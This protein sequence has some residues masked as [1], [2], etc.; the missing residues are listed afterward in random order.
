MKKLG[1][2]LSLLVCMPLQIMSMN[3]IPTCCV[4][5]TEILR[6]NARWATV[7]EEEC[8][9]E[10]DENEKIYKRMNSITPYAR[11]DHQQGYDANILNPKFFC[12]IDSNKM[13]LRMKVNGAFSLATSCCAFTA[14]ACSCPSGAMACSAVGC[15]IDVAYEAERQGDILRKGVCTS[16]GK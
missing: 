4:I 13:P 10:H 14:L 15:C 12:C 11:V 16:A 5:G 7:H 9:L 8:I 6:C 2:L 3:C 1:V